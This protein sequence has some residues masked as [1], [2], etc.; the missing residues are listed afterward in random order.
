MAQLT[1]KFVRFFFTHP[2][3]KQTHS[4]VTLRGLIIERHKINA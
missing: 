2:V 1:F 4:R 3:E